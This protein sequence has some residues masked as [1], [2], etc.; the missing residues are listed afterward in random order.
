[1][2]SRANVQEHLEVCAAMCYCGPYIYTSHT[3]VPGIQAVGENEDEPWKNVY[4]WKPGYFEATWMADGEV[5]PFS[6]D[7][8]CHQTVSWI[9]VATATAAY[10]CLCIKE[11]VSSIIPGTRYCCTIILLYTF[12]FSATHF[13]SDQTSGSIQLSIPRLRQDRS[14]RAA[15]TNHAL[16]PRPPAP[17]TKSLEVCGCVVCIELYLYQSYTSS[18]IIAL[19]LLCCILRHLSV[20][21]EK[22]SPWQSIDLSRVRENLYLLPFFSITH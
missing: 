11:S 16:P 17:L 21:F 12:Y 19:L 1:M 4:R 15:K 2:G 7:G 13:S 20:A 22:L 14:L 5:T 3:G 6:R 9:P 8:L 18:S 10:D